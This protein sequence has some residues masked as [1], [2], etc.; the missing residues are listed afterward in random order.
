MRRLVLPALLLASC[1]FSHARTYAILI[2]NSA[3]ESAGFM[4]LPGVRHDLTSA[5]QMAEALGAQADSITE[6]RDAKAA[7]IQQKLIELQQRLAPQDQVFVYY[8]GHGTRWYDEERN[9]CS[10]GLLAT[11]GQALSQHDLSAL[12]EPLARKSAQVFVLLDACFSGGVIGAPLRTRSANNEDG[13]LTPKFQS[14]PGDEACGR[15]SNFRLRGMDSK[16][17][18]LTLLAST[19]ADEVAFDSPKLGGYATLSW[20]DC[21]L[22]GGEKDARQLQRC[23][24]QKLDDLLSRKR[25][26][27]GQHLRLVGNPALKL[28]SRPDTVSTRPQQPIAIDD[29]A[30]AQ[31]RM[32][33]RKLAEWRAIAEQ[34]WPADEQQIYE[35]G[36]KRVE[37]LRKLGDRKGISNTVEQLMQRLKRRDLRAKFLYMYI[38]HLSSNGTIDRAIAFYREME[39]SG[40]H[41]PPVLVRANAA[42]AHQLASLGRIDEVD[43]WL[44]QGEML[45]K[46]DTF[47]KNLKWPSDISWVWLSARWDLASARINWLMIKGETLQAL[48]EQD[49]LM[50][51]IPTLHRQIAQNRFTYAN[52]GGRIADSYLGQASVRRS[53]GHYSQSRSYLIEAKQSIEE[54]GIYSRAYRLPQA[55]ALLEM[56]EGRFPLAERYSRQY[57][58]M[59]AGTATAESR[60]GQQALNQL[61]AS[62]VVQ[63]KWSDALLV[64]SRLRLPFDGGASPSFNWTVNSLVQ[65]F[66]GDPELAVRL[67]REEIR[68]KQR[69]SAN[70]RSFGILRSQVLLNLAEL[71]ANPE[72]ASARRELPI[73]VRQLLDAPW[74]QVVHAHDRQYLRLALRAFVGWVARQPDPEAEWQDLAFRAA[75]WI[76]EASVPL[77]VEEA[78]AR[79]RSGDPKLA[80][81][82]RTAQ[83]A[84]QLL[85]TGYE[86]LRLA[87]RQ[88]DAG[89]EQAESLQAK[90]T[91]LEDSKQRADQALRDYCPGCRNIGQPTPPTMAQVAAALKPGEVW[92]SIL[93]DREYTYAWAV[94]HRGR[95]G[96]HVSELTARQIGTLVDTLRDSLKPSPLG[97][98]PPFATERAAK[99]YRELLAPLRAIWGDGQQL[100]ISAD[101]ALSRF[102]LAALPV[103]KRWLVETHAVSQ[104][105]SAAALLALRQL[106]AQSGP[107]SFMGFGDPDFGTETRTGPAK[108][109]QGS[110][111][112]RY[113]N[114]QRLPA[115]PET[116]LELQAAAQ[117]LGTAPEQSLLLGKAATRE[118]VL[119]APLADKRIVA[120]ST[121]GLQT[122]ELD[123][124]TQPALA[125]SGSDNRALLQLEDVMKLKLNADWVLLAACNTAAGDGNEALTG[126]ARGFFYAGARSL[127]VTHWAVETESTRELIG[128]ALQSYARDPQLPR[129]Q[130]VRAAQLTLM[131]QQRWQHPYFW[132]GFELT[133]DGG[134]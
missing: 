30:E 7:S 107:L 37:A 108:T 128:Q 24:Q 95:H 47:F 54:N 26:S 73:A 31:V 125:L 6:L 57:L 12:L 101:G 106:P 90:L 52:A 105:P 55:Y 64:Q 98:L 118:A 130:A 100:L 132:A 59:L 33:G 69:T 104:T 116:R 51:M 112:A 58:E 39:Q 103:D 14:T 28:T 113:D 133:G 27:L 25:Q 129:A 131:K 2:G 76:S 5:R 16:A 18:N 15:P 77:S 70:P 74:P 21:L 13:L 84:R 41:S 43:A 81:L 79:Q 88:G 99:L 19:Q 91:T 120:F 94:D 82:T 93:P 44:K 35:Q 83:D 23:A 127:L 1:A 80:E 86:Q 32:D 10:E 72:N 111:E 85:N 56:H 78:A 97:T 48:N 68:L 117:A 42:I 123:G 115:L 36:M 92:I 17:T 11:D 45:L 22:D 65:F 29:T 60:Q 3:Y 89:R 53:A 71:Q 50:T 8:S 109:R 38:E 119:A 40:E 87:L 66:V 110:D 20:R 67:L 134:R 122:G 121:H 61:L 4:A 102:P 75:E 62:L 9:Q 63:E 49:N 124:L 34:P 126:L 46:E 96:F 114:Y